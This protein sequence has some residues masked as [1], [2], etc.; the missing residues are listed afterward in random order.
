M[1]FDI[2][3]AHFREVA[4]IM[5]GMTIGSRLLASGALSLEPLVTH[6]FD[7]ADIGAAFEAAVTSRGAS[8]GRRGRSTRVR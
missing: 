3:N 7:L 1:A 8:Q 5:R 6:R 4:T 2:V